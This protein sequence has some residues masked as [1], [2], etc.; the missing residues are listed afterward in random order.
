M[1]TYVGVRR[2]ALTGQSVAGD[3]HWSHGYWPDLLGDLKRLK[4]RVEWELMK[5]KT[6]AG[7]PDNG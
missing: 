7:T 4:C 3:V 1:R 5:E 2:F 6:N